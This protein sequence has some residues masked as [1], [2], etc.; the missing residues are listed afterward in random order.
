MEAKKQILPD[1]PA[2]RKLTFAENA[3]LT[4]KVLGTFGLIG[5]TI[6]GI[7]LWTSPQ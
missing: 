4:V 3:I 2:P 6:W 5:A 7:S 1:H